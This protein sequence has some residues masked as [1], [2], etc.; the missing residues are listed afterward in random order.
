VVL[1]V[2][3]VIV[4]AL[5][6]GGLTQVSR[7]SGG[8]DSASNR[9]LATLG[10]VVTEQSNATS[11]EVRT[12]LG[13]LPNQSRQVLQESLDSAVRQTSDQSAK[14]ELAAARASPPSLG[15]QFATVF[16]ERA[17]AMDDLRA[18]IDG[19]LGLHAD[20]PAGGPGAL[21]TTVASSSP[22]LSAAQASNRIAATGTLLR[23]ADA[24][25]GALRR[26]LAAATG[27][28]RLPTS[29]WISDPQDWQVG[30][31]A[32]TVDLMAT[33]STLAVTH[34]LVLRTVRL[35][36]PALP[37]PQGTAAGVLVISPVTRF[38]VSVVVA[39]E[40]SV[41]ERHAS[42]RISMANQTT[43]STV[44]RTQ[45]TA[46]ALGSTVGLPPVDFAVKPG[47]T[48]VLTISIVLPPGQTSTLGTATQTTVQVS[49]AT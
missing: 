12:L 36:P 17:Q 42:V 45:S 2:A 22:T 10:S 14:A 29:I 21:A 1:L 32:A 15:G 40:G 34:N 3:T 48:Y 43:G 28:G 19:L 38:E 46:V 8:Y 26:S 47:T 4:V 37:T 7:Q 49:P 33:S 23:R 24:Q 20:P 9:T 31:V 44:T 39:N 30:T 11:G 27:H 16:A 25:Y 18:A 5:V 41:D 13:D 6:V 35:N